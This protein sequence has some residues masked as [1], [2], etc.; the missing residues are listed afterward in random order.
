MSVETIRSQHSLPRRF[1]KGMLFT[2]KQQE[3][4]QIEKKTAYF[5][6]L[7]AFNSPVTTHTHTH[8]RMCLQRVLQTARLSAG[9]VCVL[10][11][12]E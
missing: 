7:A 5:T 3:G 6:S 2:L 12:V 9:H 4:R 8:T 1:R 10:R 11:V